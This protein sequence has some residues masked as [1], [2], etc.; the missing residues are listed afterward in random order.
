MATNH[1]R[2]DD[3]SKQ[4]TTQGL[5]VVCDCPAAVFAPILRSHTHTLSTNLSLPAQLIALVLH[6]PPAP[7]LPLPLLQLNS[8][9]R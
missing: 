2:R 5:Y 6:C 9:R 8:A 3:P 7:S 1:H 4:N